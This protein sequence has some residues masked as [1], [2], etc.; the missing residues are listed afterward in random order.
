LA[1]IVRAV[2]G[3][4][5]VAEDVAF[6]AVVALV[7][8]FSLVLGEL[9]PKS[10]AL[11]H[12]EGYA[13]LAGAPLLILSALVRPLVWGLTKS[14]N[15]VLRPFG[16]HAT[17]S[18]SKLSADELRQLVEEAARS[19]DLDARSGEIA[20]RALELATLN[21]GDVMVP[22]TR[23][24]A[25]PRN[26]APT[27]IK[28]LLLETGHSRMPV[29]DGAVENV[30]GYVTAKDILALDWE[31]QL[32][33]LEDILRP[34]IFLLDSMEVPD[35]LRELQARKAG[36]AF[37]VDAEGT[38]LGLLT[39]ED[40]I[41]ELIGEIV[42]E[43]ETREEPFVRERD[44]SVLVRGDAAVRDFNLSFPANLPED[45]RLSTVAGLC[46]TLAG[47]IPQPGFRFTT[48]GG[49]TV[50]IVDASPR[51]VRLVRLRHIR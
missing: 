8:Y 2:P 10:I 4:A 14:S 30:V 15:L 37:V 46:I 32:V 33:V 26:A 48:D 39:L 25:L 18:E 3:L 13:L 9:V 16:D 51:R 7:S 1:E 29:Y 24:D 42:T 27:K 34:A 35:V 49:W 41:E 36:I 40:V 31:S 11:K 43:S 21:A 22:R 45:D 28:Q 47:R 23:I 17:F 38:L 20:S 44:G 50:E 12:P 19:G 5:P 6:I